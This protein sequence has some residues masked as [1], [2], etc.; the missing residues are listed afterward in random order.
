M[1]EF[2]TRQGLVGVADVVAEPR[3]A[4][5]ITQPIA[6]IAIDRGF[7]L[8]TGLYVATVAAYLGFLGVMASAFMNPGLVLPMVIFTLFV[9]AAFGTPMLW[10]RMNPGNAQKAMSFAMFRNRGI[11]TATGHLDSGAAAAQVL[12][13]PVLIFCWAVAIAV[14]AALT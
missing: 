6:R 3:I 10:V 4:A 12:I 11:E 8:P 13:L 14:I 7:E 9:L 1:T 2:V 5:E